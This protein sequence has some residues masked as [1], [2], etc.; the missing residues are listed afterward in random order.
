MGRGGGGIIHV[1]Y[2][3]NARALQ[4]VHELCI[5]NC[6]FTFLVY[7]TIRPLVSPLE[8]CIAM[9]E[10]WH[11]HASLISVKQAARKTWQALA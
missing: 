5:I 11:G 4:T 3:D 7:S 9:Y 10:K 1:A 8:F 6:E 2:T